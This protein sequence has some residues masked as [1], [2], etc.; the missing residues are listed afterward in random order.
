MAVVRTDQHV[1]ESAG[2]KAEDAHN[3]ERVGTLLSVDAGDK[4]LLAVLRTSTGPHR[5]Q[6]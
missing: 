5:G 4:A 6:K 3:G 2:R 1:I